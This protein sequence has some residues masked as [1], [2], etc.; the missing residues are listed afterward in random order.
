LAS[1]PA[2]ALASLCSPSLALLSASSCILFSSS[3][4]DCNSL[5][6]ASDF[7]CSA[8]WACKST[9]LVSPT[10]LWSSIF[11][12]FST[13]INLA[14][15]VASA[16]A[17]RCSP[18][19]ALPRASSCSFFNFS[20]S[21]C[22]S[23]TLESDLSCCS[24]W[25]CKRALLVSST[26]FWSS[27]FA[28]ASDSVILASNPAFALASLCS[29]SL[30]LLSASS[31]I[32]FSSSI[33]DCNSLVFASDFSCSARWAC[34][35][36]RLVSPTFL[37]SSIFDA[38]S[39]SINLASIV[40][41]ALANRCSP[42]FALPRA[43][44]CSFF[45]FSISN[46][47][48]LTL[49]SDLSCCSCWACKRAHLVSS[50]FFRSSIFAAAST[51][52]KRAF[53]AMT[54]SFSA[55]ISRRAF[56]R[57]SLSSK[58]FS[59]WDVNS[60]EASFSFSWFLLSW[61]CADLSLAFASS[62][63]LI[64][65]SRALLCFSCRV[66]ISPQSLFISSSDC[67]SASRDFFKAFF[68]SSASWTTESIKT[69]ALIFDSSKA[70]WAS[71]ARSFS[72]SAS[73]FAVSKSSESF[74]ISSANPTR[75]D[76]EALCDR[77]W[78]RCRDIRFCSIFLWS[79]TFVFASLSAKRILNPN[80]LSLSSFAVKR[81][82]FRSSPNLSISIRCSWSTFFNTE[83]SIDRATSLDNF[84]SY[85]CSSFEWA[86]FSAMNEVISNWAVRDM[87]L[88]SCC[89]FWISSS[90]L[91]SEIFDWSKEVFNMSTSSTNSVVVFFAA[92]S[93][94][95][96]A[97]WTTVNRSLPALNWR[98]AFSCSFFNLVISSSSL[99][100]SSLSSLAVCFFSAKLCA[101]SRASRV[102]FARC[103]K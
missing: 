74:A 4:C 69:W 44:S 60:V 46:C 25:A 80:A 52:V 101:F 17:N 86:S 35:S 10:F 65:V 5:V 32:L 93:D 23:L 66:S 87:S 49:E 14:S 1:N 56:R 42:S 98:C 18:S 16:L 83:I 26:L 43:S 39:T 103:S 37:W 9:R 45:N 38:F 96:S 72:L 76:S 53:A 78:A 70:F 22:S 67:I 3:I 82:L 89:N 51:S 81:A 54:R 90:A 34:K 71:S 13:S 77:A 30:A 61:S 41:S 62:S 95:A 58:I 85:C 48:S 7:S 79:S 2:F 24:C 73:S 55:A 94:A 68:V 97:A 102:S 15:I 33:C 19:F 28:A 91:R 63:S 8:R 11:D 40:A 31:C 64:S 100:I 12:A 27:I 59:C 88:M 36:T 99:R 75:S 29:P 20:I 50:T 92:A 6:F 47:S 21:N 57:A 84:S